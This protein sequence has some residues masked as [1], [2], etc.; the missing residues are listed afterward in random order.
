MHG[1][2]EPLVIALA[3]MLIT[4]AGSIWVAW[5]CLRSKR[6][7]LALLRFRQHSSRLTRLST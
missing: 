2:P 1:I 3:V 4:L 6:W 7:S 5:S